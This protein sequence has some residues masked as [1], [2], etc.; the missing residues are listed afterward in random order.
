MNAPMVS[1]KVGGTNKLE[2]I[3]VVK[4]ED[5]AYSTVY[6]SS[7]DAET[8]EFS[9]EDKDFNSDCFYYLRVSQVSEVPGR[10]WTYPT[11]DMAWSSPVWVEYSK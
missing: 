5:G 8:T 11:N 10:L 9:I 4:Y 1:G 2:T 7:P 3:E 6:R